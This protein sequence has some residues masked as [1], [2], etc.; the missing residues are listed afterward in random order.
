M[1]RSLAYY[2]TW[3][4]EDFSE[5]CGRR[6]QEIGLSQ[7]LLF[8]ILYVGKHPGCSPKA[9]AEALRMDFGHVA[10]SLSKLEQ[11]GFIRQEQNPRDR[12]AHLLC[13]T[14]HGQTA[15][16]LSYDLFDEWDREVLGQIEEADREQLLALLG[17]LT[18]A[19]EG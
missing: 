18:P 16:A 7:G 4:R 6:L 17:Q 9:L 19:L 2:V 12:R 11:A 8:F 14:D 15:F 13:L 10:R 5:Y 1:T 3:L